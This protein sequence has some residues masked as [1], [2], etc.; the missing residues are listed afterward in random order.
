MTAVR[1]ALPLARIQTSVP[2]TTT[3]DLTRPIP[4]PAERGAPLWRERRKRPVV[5]LFGVPLA[6]PIVLAAGLEPV[7]LRL[8]F[9]A[10]AAGML[11]LLL[12]A[13]RRS[14]IETSTVTSRFVTVEQPGGGRVA[15]P[16]EAVE[17]VTIQGDSVRI[18]TAR[19]V[20]T[21]GF[22]RRQRRLI[23]VLE[24]VAPGVTVDRDVTAFCPT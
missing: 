5:L 8:V 3:A 4:F 22:V 20:L 21:L 15:I 24:Q 2:A 17:R 23:R 9:A 14:L 19:G 18:D 12:R 10:V 6:F 11:A 13:R 16:T 1:I 7:G